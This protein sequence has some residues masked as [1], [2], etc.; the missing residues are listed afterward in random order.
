MGHTG[1]KDKGNAHDKGAGGKQETLLSFVV[2]TGK[3]GNKVIH[4]PVNNSNCSI[5]NNTLSPT[6]SQKNEFSVNNNLML[7]D[8]LLGCTANVGDKEEPRANESEMILHNKILKARR[9]IEELKRALENANKENEAKKDEWEK[10]KQELLNANAELSARVSLLEGELSTDR[11][12]KKTGS[13][14]RKHA[15]VERSQDSLEQRKSEQ[16]K[17]TQDRVGDFL[18]AERNS[19]ARKPVAIAND[20][21]NYERRER[22]RRRN[23]LVLRFNTQNENESKQAFGEAAQKLEMNENNFRIKYGGRNMTGTWLDDDHTPREIEIQKWL[24]HL[25]RQRRE[26]G[27]NVRVGY[28]GLVKSDGVEKFNELTAELELVRRSAEESF[29]R[30]RSVERSRN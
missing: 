3:E 22:K 8:E 13:I 23:S 28:L 5:N 17:T 1:K 6:S 7:L 27:E 15:P 18:N 29:R 4:S 30:R 14:N 20:H 9:E 19:A 21:L 2:K 10:E 16:A 12:G 26:N 11:S 24:R 25:A